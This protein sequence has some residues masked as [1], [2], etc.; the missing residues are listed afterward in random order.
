VALHRARGEFDKERFSPSGELDVPLRAAA[1]DA[2]EQI[3][4]RVQGDLH[5]MLLPLDVVFFPS[6]GIGWDRVVY[7]TDWPSWPP[8]ANTRKGIQRNLELI[9]ASA[10]RAA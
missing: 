4:D 5:R 1:L 2:G 10:G 9:E 6:T 8:V 7:A 3:V